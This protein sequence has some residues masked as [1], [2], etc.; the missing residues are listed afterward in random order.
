MTTIT[1][2]LDPVVDSSWPE[3]DDE[4]VLDVMPMQVNEFTCSGCFLIH[5][6]SQLASRRRNQLI[7]RDCA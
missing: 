1:D 5:H 3:T 7:C 4:L 2:V 6:R